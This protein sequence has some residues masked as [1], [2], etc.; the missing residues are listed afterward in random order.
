MKTLYFNIKVFIFEINSF[1]TKEKNLQMLPPADSKAVFFF[2]LIAGHERTMS[3]SIKTKKRY[4]KQ[5]VKQAK[6]LT[7]RNVLVIHTQTRTGNF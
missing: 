5:R 4:K 6:S 1:F 2:F 7:D 3:K